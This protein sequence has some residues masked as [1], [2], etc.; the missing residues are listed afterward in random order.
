MLSRIL[1]ARPSQNALKQSAYPIPEI[2]DN[3]EAKG[4]FLTYDKLSRNLKESNFTYLARMSVTLNSLM[5]QLKRTSS[6]GGETNVDTVNY[7]TTNFTRGEET[8]YEFDYMFSKN[9]SCYAKNVTKGSLSLLMKDAWN[10]FQY[11]GIVSP[12]WNL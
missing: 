10:D 1:T 5:S 8:V 3:F 2:P 7:S 6:A 11:I 4:R 9:S 12:T